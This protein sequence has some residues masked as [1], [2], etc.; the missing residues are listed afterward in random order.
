MQP[1]VKGVTSEISGNDWVLEFPDGSGGY[2]DP[3][4][5]GE[6]EDIMI[7][8]PHGEAL[9]YALYEIMSQSHTMMWW[10]GSDYMIT[11]DPTILEHLPP[12]YVENFGTPPLVKSGADILAEIAKT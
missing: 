9:F 2:M 12:D 10:S 11:A 6:H 8:R 7:N 1:F 3:V 4:V 5:E